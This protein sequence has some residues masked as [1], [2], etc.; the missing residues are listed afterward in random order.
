MGPEATRHERSLTVAHSAHVALRDTLLRAAAAGYFQLYWSDEIL[1]EAR[2]NLVERCIIDEDQ[3]DRPFTM[4]GDE[5]HP[6]R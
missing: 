2:R 4:H 5:G 6:L 1:A 3:A